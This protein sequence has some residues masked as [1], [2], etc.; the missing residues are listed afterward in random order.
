MKKNLYFLHQWLFLFWAWTVCSP[1][2]NCDKCGFKDSKCTKAPRT[3]EVNWVIYDIWIPMFRKHSSSTNCIPVKSERRF[4]IKAY[5]QNKIGYSSLDW[6][7]FYHFNDLNVCNFK[8]NSLNYDR[9]V[10]NVSSLNAPTI[11]K[12][13]Q[14]IQSNGDQSSFR[15]TL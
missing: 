7:H 15:R 1:F 9:K 14:W 3:V 10:L 8:S 5:S 6:H 2:C 12:F 13:E 11:P 4:Q